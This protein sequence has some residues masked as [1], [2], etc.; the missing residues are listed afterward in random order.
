[1]SRAIDTVTVLKM[2]GQLLATKRIVRRDGK[3]LIDPYSNAKHFFWRTERVSGLKDIHRILLG[4]STHPQE[5]I[6]RGVPRDGVGREIVRRSN[7]PDATIAPADPGR[8]WCAFDFDAFKTGLLR[9]DPSREELLEVGR[10]ARA[11]LPEGFHNAASVMRL[12]ASAGVEGWAEASFHLWFWLSRP[13]CDKS[14]QEWAKSAGMDASFYT[15]V[16][17]HYTASPVFEGMEDPVPE[18]ILLLDGTPEATPPEDWLDLA[19]WC[20]REQRKADELLSKRPN[21][22]DLDNPNTE[23]RKRRW[24]LRA[25]ENACAEIQESGRGSRHNTAFTAAIAIGGLVATGS[26]D[27]T[28]AEDALIKAIQ[29]VVPQDR[30]AKEAAAVREGI[31][32]GMGRPRDISHVGSRAPTPPPAAPMSPGSDLAKTLA[33]PATE[34]EKMARFCGGLLDDGQGG[35]RVALVA[36]LALGAPVKGHEVPHGYWI[37]GAAVG[38]WKRAAGGVL[39]YPVIEHCPIVITALDEELEGR[40]R[41]RV[42]WKSGAKQWRQVWLPREDA[43]SRRGIEKHIA[44]GFPVTS[45]SSGQV[46]AFLA[47]YLAANAVRIPRVRTTSTFGWQR[48][49]GFMVGRTHI[50]PDGRAV[51]VDLDDPTTWEGGAIAFKAAPDDAGGDALAAALRPS[52][53]FR[54]WREAIRSVARYP[55]ATL[56]VIVSLA[57]PLLEVLDAPNFLADW[58]FRTSSG[59][60]T[61][62]QLGASVWGNPSTQASEFIRPWSATATNIERTAVTLRSIPLILDD[63][64]QARFPDQVSQAIYDL[65]KGQSKPRGTK[66]GTERLS[67][68]RL[69]ILSTGEQPATSFGSGSQARGGA[70]TRALEISNAPFGGESPETGRVVRELKAALAENYGHAGP[71]FVAGLLQRRECWPDWRKRV[72]GFAKG[73]ASQAIDGA[74]SRVTDVRAIL[75]F[76]HELAEEILALGI[77]SPVGDVFPDI[78]LGVQDAASEE[79]A[80]HAVVNEFVAQRKRFR[81]AVGAGNDPG[82]AGWIGAVAG[83]SGRTVR[84]YVAFPEHWMDAFLER[85]GLEKRA[86]ITGWKERDW[87]VRDHPHFT[88]K[89]TIDGVRTRM[90]CLDLS[91]FG[92]EDAVVA[93]TMTPACTTEEAD[94]GA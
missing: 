55:R 61:V 10:R 45:E 3:T 87:L 63:T 77:P 70:K 23:D 7:G 52:G 40:Q 59:K 32:L 28:T 81:G 48:D 86:V 12:S 20:E 13:V 46:V 73:Y 65:A 93:R 17:H 92:A 21:P 1:M 19:S 85:M 64:A 69:S 53:T 91:L 4:L 11:M 5:S 24:C 50:R 43:F 35:K 30:H 68:F 79:R 34:D 51:T 26:L 75:E 25:L 33:L 90:V 37:H 41:V 54:S 22:I 14:L 8:R 88:K 38:A 27:R 18:R 9:H 94:D 80:L 74:T 82:P 39:K 44:N 15:P 42:A 6:I 2:K 78:L 29:S 16:Q 89:V 60:T 58:A 66:S 62:L 67:Y 36:E 71:M 31:E 47:A 72:A 49:E 84:P 56:G 57:S 76:T 83:K